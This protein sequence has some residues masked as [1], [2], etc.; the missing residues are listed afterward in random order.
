MKRYAYNRLVLASGQ[1]IPG[2]VVIT[3]DMQ[4]NMIEWHPLQGEEPMVEWIG[5]TFREHCLVQQ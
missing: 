5:G 4:S 2:P 1:V 3:C